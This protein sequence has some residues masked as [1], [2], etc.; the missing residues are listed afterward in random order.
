MYKAR[1]LLRLL[2]VAHERNVTQRP[3]IPA[4]SDTSERHMLVRRTSARRGQAGFELLATHRPPHYDVVLPEASPEHA[5]TLLA[6]FGRG[7]P[8]PHRRPR[9]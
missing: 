3:A 8:N 7:A 1:D 4:P 6:V 5:S 9:R 2:R